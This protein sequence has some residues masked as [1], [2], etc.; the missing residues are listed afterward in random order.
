MLERLL[1][2][3]N[4]EHFLSCAT[5][6]QLLKEL[7]NRHIAY[8]FIYEKL[9]KVT[10]TGCLGWAWTNCFSSLIGLIE[11]GNKRLETVEHKVDS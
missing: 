11:Y 10:G 8:V 3:N 1:S 9:G 2:K 7:S 5:T 6:E 4:V